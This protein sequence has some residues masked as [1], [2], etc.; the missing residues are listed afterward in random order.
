MHEHI[1]FQS[2]SLSSSQ[3]IE[4]FFN[5][6]A[7]LAN[8]S[9]SSVPLQFLVYSYT[10]PTSCSAP[11]PSIIDYSS[12]FLVTSVGV[13]PGDNI[14]ET[15]VAQLYLLHYSSMVS[16]A[17]Q[18]GPKG[19]C[20]GATDN[21]QTQSNQWCITFLVKFKSFDVIRPTIVQGSRLLQSILYFKVKQSSL[22]KHRS[23][24]TAQHILG[25][26]SS[27]NKGPE[28]VLSN[29]PTFWELL[30]MQSNAI[31]ATTFLA[32]FMPINAITLYATFTELFHIFN[33]SNVTLSIIRDP[34]RRIKIFSNHASGLQDE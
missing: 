6:K 19:V 27:I 12:R 13:M 16:T 32:V 30:C 25:M 2:P 11:V 5:S 10:P 4:D 34:M 14:S 18:Y 24:S 20:M 9:M 17:S 1:S 22:S 31:L 15:V 8:T 21:A 3:E 28:S 33:P 7:L 29:D 23:L 26:D